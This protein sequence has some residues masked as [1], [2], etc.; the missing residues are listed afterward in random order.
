[1]KNAFVA[2]CRA[3]FVLA[4]A[5]LSSLAGA[6]TGGVV[7]GGNPVATISG[8]GTSVTTINQ[9]ANQAIINW[10]QFSIGA[11]DTVKFVQPS[12]NAI[13]LNRVLGGD[14][15]QIYGTLQA[16]GR[17]IVINPNG[18]MVGPGGMVDT[19][20]FIAS[21][22]DVPD[23]AF[24][25]GG[26]MLFSGQST[27][28]VQNQGTI[29]ALGGDV[30]LIAHTVDNSGTITAPQG[31]VG[32]A[33]GSQVELVP[34]GDERIS[35][36]AGNSS[37][38]AAIGVNNSGSIAAASAELKAAGGNI[39]ALAINNGGVVRAT[40]IVNENGHIYLRADGGNIQ[41]SG[42]LAA[43]N[44]DGS[45]GTIVMDG[46]DNAANPSTVIN[47]GTIDASGKTGGTVEM[48][49]DN[50]G[51]FDNALVNVS[52]DA[53]GGTALI[54]GDLH[55]ANPAIQDAEHTLIS[56]DATIKAD[57]ISQGNGGEIVLWSDNT[58][59]D[60]GTLS[61]T[62]GAAGGNG[63]YAEVSSKGVVDFGGIADLTA[64]D[65]NGGTLLFDPLN[66]TISTAAAANVTGFNPPTVNTEAFTDDAGLTSN[67]RLTGNP[68]TTTFGGV[69]DG[70]TIVLE[71]KNN[72]TVVDTFNI[73]TETGNNNVSLDLRAG[74][75]ID[76][77]AAVIASGSGTLTLSANDSGAAPAS[78]VGAVNFGANGSLTTSGGAIN[79]S[80]AAI[81]VAGFGINA[82]G[83]TA[84]NGG[85]IILNATGT[86]AVNAPVFSEGG[87]ATTVGLNGGN[88]QITGATITSTS[89]SVNTSGSAAAN[90]IGGSAGTITATSTG[91]VTL[92][93]LTANGGAGAG[94]AGGNAAE[95]SVSAGNGITLNN[96]L[97]A[98][99][100]TGTSSG[101]NAP[102][103]LDATVGGVSQTAG[104]LDSGGLLLLGAGTFD[105]ADTG[106]TVGTL[107]ANVTGSLIYQDSGVLTVSTVLATSGITSGNNPINVS[108]ANSSLTISKN[109]NA[110][111]ATANLTAGGSG[112][113]LTIAPLVS[114]SGTGGVNLSA[115]NMTID[116]SATISAGSATATLA[117]SQNGVAINLGG[118][119]G[120]GTLGLTSGELNTVTAGTLQ[121]GNANSG[122]LTV[123]APIT[124]PTTAGT[125]SLQSGSTITQ[126][127]GDTITVAGPGVLNLQSAGTITL[128]EA[129]L[130]ANLSITGGTAQFT[131]AQNLNIEDS[132]NPGQTITL[133][134]GGAGLT[135]GETT[136]N[137]AG[138]LNL[139]NW[140]AT[141]LTQ[142]NQ[143]AALKVTGA[144]GALQFST[145]ATTLD[146]Q[147]IADPTQ[148]V[149]LTGL[150]PTVN[151]TE[152]TGI[153]NASTLV[154]NNLGN[155][156]LNQAN[157]VGVLNGS[158]L[159]S[160]V[161]FTDAQNLNI[162]GLVG[163]GTVTLTGSG[164]PTLNESTGTIIQSRLNLN[165]WG[166]TTLN[167]ANII[168]NFSV[169]GGTG[170]IQFTDGQN[171]D[172]LGITAPNQTVTLMAAGVDALSETSGTITAGV[173]N[174]N[175][176]TTTTLNQA[177]QVG[178]LAATSPGTGAFQF[179]TGGA[180]DI[181]G[182]SDA[183]QTVTLSGTGAASTVTESTGI[184]NANELDLN[185]P[186]NINLDQANS[187]NFLKIANS[188]SV[189]QFTDASSLTVLGIDAAGK[190]VTLNG[191]ATMT[192]GQSTGII[193]AGQLNLNNWAA[194]TLNQNNQVPTLSAAGITGVFSFTTFLPLDV[195]GISDPSFA[196]TL[197]G[198][199]NNTVTESTGIINTPTLILQSLGTTTLNQA[200]TVGNLQVTG[201][202][203]ALQFTD[204]QSLNVE[205]VAAT[206]Q[207]VTIAATG[208][209]NELTV[210]GGDNVTGANVTLAGDRINLSGTVT[211]PGVAA[212]H[213]STSGRQIIIG[214][215]DVSAPTASGGTLGLTTA[216]LSSITA[217]TL[218]V[219]DASSG[220]VSI[221]AILAPL[222]FPT[223]SLLSGAT[224]SEAPGT[225]ITIGSLA[226]QAAGGIN[227]TTGNN[228]T[229]F[230]AIT[231]GLLQFV[232]A[233]SL[234][235]GNADGIVGIQAGGGADITTQSGTLTVNSPINGPGGVTLTANEMAINATI[236][237]GG[238]NTI[239]QP[240]TAG[241]SANFGPTPIAGD[242]NLTQTELNKVTANVLQVGNNLSGAPANANL[243]VAPLTVNQLLILGGNSSITLLSQQL[244]ALS[245][246]ETPAP[247]EQIA[248][249]S[250][251]SLSLDE[252]SKILPAGAIGTIWLQLPFPHETARTYKVEDI[253]KWT[254]G[255]M[256]AVGSTAGPQTPR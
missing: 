71:A 36:L 85:N 50:V 162:Q 247:T 130:V 53:G 186:G 238:A 66:I 24:L 86:L 161:Q 165:N 169:T 29:R 137:L 7:V 8:Q 14:L 233:G 183:G 135:L 196:V 133:T 249:F 203:G 222:T 65:G 113:L 46:G 153:I 107:A 114:V 55:G 61:A 214:T 179:E 91:A 96:G 68:T 176:W 87:T 109:V 220:N 121:V 205:N 59:R 159:G 26:P 217:G 22:L 177:N 212:I 82:T 242:L 17:V 69:G 25:S 33:A 128:N 140:G 89:G 139:N 102:I 166:T 241:I 20:G 105:I 94:L 224:V 73:A 190:T 62:G 127:S 145:F 189:T 92:G 178:V 104:A 2:G 136:G 93:N 49:G 16:N 235:I 156:T 243:V 141:T 101:N 248:Q 32:L 47:Y 245:A 193:A 237:S 194:T 188:P 115:D 21:T 185:G 78:G 142:P 39:Y 206:G 210:A 76:V 43:Q 208:D 52:G 54:G 19:K 126:N 230:A 253:S 246:V 77:N 13:A 134:A 6:P 148:T 198:G 219:G 112:N 120:I 182:I 157:T 99:G 108:T 256:A 163:G 191:A 170:A 119:N 95:I 174:V 97:T 35:V 10:Q 155:T 149:T 84:N 117:Q 221:T 216:E 252:A 23:N 147:G 70:A 226:A 64:S 234:S 164:S 215:D 225:S 80:G 146:I 57:A 100:G 187:I 75:D 200:N 27:A 160:T 173:L 98:L 38:P 74:N 143:V 88:V 207:S 72:I 58:T 12:A 37:S 255:P 250:S 106:D 118:A 175:S 150:N 192:L 254:S 3:A 195:R 111:S 251:A 181:Q 168:D 151:V 124:A 201:A 28:A 44:A 34:S 11:G 122:A 158:G 218:R 236:N 56:P 232:N 83:S 167:Q 209:N 152:S 138:Q 229:T 81:T 40:G 42:T 204:A 184:I 213:E 202:A 48:L 211:T 131:D 15:T 45:G 90:G 5:P 125:F 231:P 103:S 239:L 197:I 18:I 60:Y 244:A 154:L 1:M 51:L 123:V 171:L 41:N 223:L 110:G 132:S 228:V 67:F 9:S 129:N 172:V 227:L 199:G 180:V 31:T 63:G 79:V 4:L 116:S 144:T 30:F 240:F